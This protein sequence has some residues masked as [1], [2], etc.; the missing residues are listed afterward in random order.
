MPPSAELE[1]SDKLAYV[2]YM[3]AK[4]M[5]L[6]NYFNHISPEGEDPGDRIGKSGIK[7]IF[8]GGENISQGQSNGTEAGKSWKKSPG[9][10]RNMMDNSHT[11]VGVARYKDRFVMLLGSEG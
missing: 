2:A 10:C 9:H 8:W 11:H 6:R 3:H 7:N 4:D 1:W 5:Y